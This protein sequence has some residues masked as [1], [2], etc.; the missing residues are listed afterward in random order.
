MNEQAPPSFLPSAS[1]TMR[2]CVGWMTVAALA[3]VALVSAAFETFLGGSPVRWWMAGSVVAYL[4]GLRRRGAWR[5]ACGRASRRWVLRHWGVACSWG[6]SRSPHGYRA[7][8]PTASACSGRRH[9][10]CAPRCQ[11]WLLRSRDCHLCGCACSR[12]GPASRWAR[13]LHME[14]CP[15]RSGSRIRRRMS[16]SSRAV[17]SG[18]ACRAGC[19]ARSSEP[20]SLTSACAAGTGCR[21]RAPPVASRHPGRVQRSTGHRSVVVGCDRHIRRDRARRRSDRRRRGDSVDWIQGRF[22]R[23]KSGRRTPERG[24]D[25]SGARAFRS[26]V[27]GRSSAHSRSVG[28]SA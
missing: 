26:G 22:G 24:P 20:W 3:H 25:R 10:C 19:R 2:V 4:A 6:C 27:D 14:S 1:S 15:S 13:S 17:P 5:R 8:L 9:R 11:P 21:T 12:R 18:R 28:R 7:G 16:R 23:G